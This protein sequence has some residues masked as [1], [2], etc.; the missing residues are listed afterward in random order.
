MN[1]KTMKHTKKIS[2]YVFTNLKLALIASI[3]FVPISHAALTSLWSGNGNT[4]DLVAGHNGTLVN[5]ASFDSGVFDQSFRFDGANDF[6]SVPDNN[7]WTF[8]SNPFSI[9]L[10]ANFDLIKTGSIGAL[11]N[12]FIAHDTGGGTQSKWVFLYDGNGNLGF[13]INGPVSGR[14]DFAAP[15]TFFPTVNE[16]THFAITRSGSTYTFYADGLSLGTETN[17]LVI[18]NANALLTI[19]EAEGLGLFDGRLD[20]IR[21]YDEALSASQISQLSMIPEPSYYGIMFT[22]LALVIR[23][24]YPQKRRSN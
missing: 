22:M 8:G 3:S 9:S 6:V 19:G 2:R 17:S 15:T 20:E 13:H 1:N 5:G 24:L 10:W 7:A 23:V 14:A 11:P 16:W 4:I 12:V 21:I 18:E